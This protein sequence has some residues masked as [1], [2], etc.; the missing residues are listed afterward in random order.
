MARPPYSLLTL[1]KGLRV[2][3]LIAD[4]AGDIG[5]TQLSAQLDEPVTVVFRIVRTLV[6]LGYVN[7][8][9]RT[10]R[11][12][13]GLRIWEM[14]EKA[15]ARLDIVEIVQPVL[16]RLTRLTG[17]TSSFAINQGRDFLYVATVNGLQPLRAYVEPGARIP[18]AM[19]TA[20]GRA[21]LAFSPE[22]V[23]DQILSAKLQRFT[24][25]TIVDPNRIRSILQEIHRRRVSI[26]HGENQPQLSAVAAPIIDSVGR[27]FGAIAM[28][29]VT[30]ERFEGKALEKIVQLVKTETE[31]VNELIRNTNRRVDGVKIAASARKKAKA[32]S[33]ELGGRSQ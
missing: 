9:P 19:P 22:D 21:I 17:E 26:V 12:A 30:Q 1:E 2:L 15:I 31:T 3:E 33:T 32:N 4:N 6:S 25:K 10:K 8:D 7:Q 11:Y 28:S 29:G 5:V 24:P 16:T 18:L 27:C 14:S 13:L 23:V 20:S